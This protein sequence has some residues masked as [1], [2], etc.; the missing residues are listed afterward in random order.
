V[1][2][3][4]CS[5]ILSFWKINRLI[6]GSDEGFRFGR[7][8]KVVTGVLFCWKPTIE[9][10][11]AAHQAGCNMIVTHEELNFPPVYSGASFESDLCGATFQRVKLL[12]RYNITS[13][14]AHG[15][16]D[17]LCILE[18]FA[19]KL[20]LTNPDVYGDYHQRLYRIGPMT[21][22]SFCEHVK[23]R[24]GLPFLRANGDPSRI[25]SL[26]GLVWGGVGISAN[27]SFIQEF[28][29]HG[30]DVLV[31]GEAEEIPFMTAQDAGACYLE[32]AH[33]TSEN[34]GLRQAMNMIAAQ[35]PDVP[36]TFY[37]NGR[38]WELVKRGA[39]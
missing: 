33:A 26:A 15:S 22:G 4:I 12:S 3:I 5:D 28:L 27:P 32:T 1:I 21:F 7:A 13:F 25:V 8:D 38:P 31:C 6:L 17:T 24:I 19:E 37:E 39:L 20:G 14:R 34:I 29:Q 36:M 16:L 10:I 11:E 9:A 18:A 23:K 35:F 30:A 2:D